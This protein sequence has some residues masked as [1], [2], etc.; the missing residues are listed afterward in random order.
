MAYIPLTQE[1]KDIMCK[2]I[3]EAD[4][5]LDFTRE[6]ECEEDNTLSDC[7]YKRYKSGDKTTTI[8]V[9]Q[10]RKDLDDR[11]LKVPRT[12]LSKDCNHDDDDMTNPCSDCTEFCFPIGCMV[13]R[14]QT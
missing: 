11:T 3:Q 1:L 14:D 6:C 7:H 2:C 12:N 13:D 4:H 8:K 9:L 10:L 5:M